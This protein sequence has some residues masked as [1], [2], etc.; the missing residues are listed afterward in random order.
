MRRSQR[1]LLAAAALA[2]AVT[3][4]GQKSGGQ[5]QKGPPPLAVDT[6]KANRQDIATF[7][8]LDGQIAPVQQATLSTPQSGNVVAVYVNEGQRVSRGELLAKLD[9]ST[10]RAQLAQQQG[11]VQQTSAQLSGANLQAPVTAAQASNTIVTAQQQ[12]AAAR[13]NVSTAQ[14]A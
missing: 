6:A 12:L 13:N 2:V 9:D 10:L 5:A 3:A 11:I 14:A 8:A 1:T 4:C 7:V